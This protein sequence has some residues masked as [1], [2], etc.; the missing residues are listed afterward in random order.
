MLTD[1]VL[2]RCP[3][4]LHLCVGHENLL[5]QQVKTCMYISYTCTYNVHMWFTTVRPCMYIVHTCLYVVHAC[6]SCSMSVHGSSLF[7][8]EHH[9]HFLEVCCLYLACTWQYQLK[10]MLW[11]RNWQFGTGIVHRGMYPLRMARSG[12]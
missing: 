4:V 10:T 7:I 3:S 1:T 6:L 11:Y 9:F 2:K 12:G 8:L 5:G